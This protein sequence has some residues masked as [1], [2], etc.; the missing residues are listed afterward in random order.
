MNKPVHAQIISTAEDGV[1]LP[2]LT[3]HAVGASLAAEEAAQQCLQLCR[4][5]HKL[6]GMLTAGNA[7]LDVELW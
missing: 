5:I 6:H 1:P 4:R 2:A 3:P 7:L